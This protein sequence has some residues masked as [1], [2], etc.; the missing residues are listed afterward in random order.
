MK[1]RENEEG[2]KE[3]LIENMDDLWYLKNIIDKNTILR[4][5]VMRREER[6]DDMERSKETSR[7]PVLMEIVPE[8]VNFQPFTDRLRIQGV[9]SKG[10]EGTPGQHQAIYVSEG[11]N[12]EIFKEKWDNTST[13]LFRDA[14]LKSTNNGLFIVMDDESATFCLLRE[15]G[16]QVQAKIFSGK[17][18]KEYASNYSRKSYFDEIKKNLKSIK[19]RGNVIIT[20]PGFEGENFKN[21]LDEDST[22]E[23]KIYFVPSTREDENAV[24]EI[25]NTDAV[26]KIL[27]DSRASRERRYMERFLEGL[28]K[29][30]MV[31]YGKNEI[32][33]VGEMGAISNLLVLEDSL[34]K[35]GTEELMN[36]VRSSGGEVVII[37]AEGE[38]GDTLKNFGGIVALLRYNI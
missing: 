30:S 21:Y 3:I 13:D 27:G 38:Y 31:A 19:F 33:K 2:W 28:A 1:I 26:R 25:I 12:I 36:L 34:R 10:P 20:G 6:S 22:S 7:K 4:K 15:Y 18:G 32:R 14:L 17:S 8:E 35:E 11:E 5:T 23:M 24:F 16:L 37:S 9:I 29:N